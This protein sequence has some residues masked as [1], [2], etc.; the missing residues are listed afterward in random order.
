MKN[1]SM[2]WIVSDVYTKDDSREQNDPRLVHA[3]T[4]TIFGVL[5]ASA[6]VTC[7]NE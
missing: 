5:A 4:Q 1:T 7:V 2:T 6:I 3:L